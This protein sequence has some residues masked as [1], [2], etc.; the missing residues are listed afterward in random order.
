MASDI[1]DIA[2]QINLLSINA[3]IEVV[4]SGEAGRGFVGSGR[5]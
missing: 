3:S 5:R 2:A 4:R 1:L